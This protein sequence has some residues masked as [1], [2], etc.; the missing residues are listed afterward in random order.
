[1]AGWNAGA[2]K[3]GLDPVSVLTAS[4]LVKIG[5]LQEW[6]VSLSKELSTHLALEI[7]KVREDLRGGEA[8][9]GLPLPHSEMSHR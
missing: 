6:L 5:I 4:S 3:G 8:V 7:E 1:M 2:P 9:A